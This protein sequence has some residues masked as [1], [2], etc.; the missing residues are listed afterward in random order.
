MN[1]RTKMNDALTEVRQIE[2]GYIDRVKGKSG[3]MN[4]YLEL[5]YFSGLRNMLAFVIHVMA[6]PIPEKDYDE[7]LKEVLHQE[8]VN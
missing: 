8:V 4:D 2:G 6:E 7:L 1:L 3:E 5:N